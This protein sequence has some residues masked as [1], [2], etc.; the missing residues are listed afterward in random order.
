MMSR[1][2]RLFLVVVAWVVAGLVPVG[3]LNAKCR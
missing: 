2:V 3:L 1:V